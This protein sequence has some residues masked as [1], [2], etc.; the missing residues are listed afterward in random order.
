[1]EISVTELS[2]ILDQVDGG[3]HFAPEFKL[4]YGWN[5]DK[6]DFARMRPTKNLV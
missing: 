2:S 5:R 4:G 6:C 3:T 1:M